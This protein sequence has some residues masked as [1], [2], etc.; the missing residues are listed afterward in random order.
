M[1]STSHALSIGS[2]FKNLGLWFGVRGV[3]L[4]FETKETCEKNI[5][6]RE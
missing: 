3:S 6:L 5:R 1:A 4:W 2:L